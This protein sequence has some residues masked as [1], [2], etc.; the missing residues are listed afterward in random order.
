M[1]LGVKRTTLNREIK[2]LK[3]LNSD[4]DLNKLIGLKG[5]AFTYLLKQLATRVVAKLLLSQLYQLI[6]RPYYIFKVKLK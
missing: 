5:K 2:D 1:F 3:D 6:S 4:H